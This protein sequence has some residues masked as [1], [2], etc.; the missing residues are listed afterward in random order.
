MAWRDSRNL[1]T[2]GEDIYGQW[3]TVDGSLSGEN[4]AISDALGD[5]VNPSVSYDPLH[6]QFLVLWTDGRD[7]ATTG[8]DIYGQ[9]VSIY[10]LL[11]GTASD[12]NF[13]ISDA[14]GDQGHASAAYDGVNQRFMAVWADSRNVGTTGLDLYGQIVNADGSLSTTPS[15]FNFLI[16]NADNAQDLPW[17]CL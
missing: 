9:R 2:T 3:I 10:D 1:G 16:S 6:W 5:Q 4:F 8:E 14:S 11:L 7:A 15:N 17:R 12:V 13:V